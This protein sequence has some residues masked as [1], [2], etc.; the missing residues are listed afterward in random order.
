MALVI[1]AME[2][3]DVPVMVTQILPLLMMMTECRENTVG[4][5]V[6]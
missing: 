3:V 2:Q 1:L 5:D 6:F 4:N